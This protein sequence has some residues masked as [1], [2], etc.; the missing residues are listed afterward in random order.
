MATYQDCLTEKL[1]EDAHIANQNIVS[2]YG[3][4]LRCKYGSELTDHEV[5]ILFKVLKEMARCKN[6]KGNCHHNPSAKYFEQ[7]PDI[8]NG[9][10]YFLHRPCRYFGQQIEETATQRVL[11]SN[12][13]DIY[14]AKLWV[15]YIMDETNETAIKS[16]RI[17]L[18]K[19]AEGVGL[20]IYG[21]VGTGK[22]FLASLIA[23]EL[24]RSGRKIKWTTFDDL[25]RQLKETFKSDTSSEKS[26]LE[27]ISRC[28]VLFIDDLRLD[29][30]TNYQAEILFR[31][32]DSRYTARKPIYFT[33]TG[34]PE[35]L[36]TALNNPIDLKN[37]TVDGTA[38]VTRF[39]NWIYP[40]EI[41]GSSKR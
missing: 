3:D 4:K 24:L 8:I 21:E 35:Q 28:E 16:A 36:A 41:T 33:S 31:I 9:L 5:I 23:K 38:I 20:W 40:A 11:K 26:I 15:D 18:E 37:S 22:T 7:Y 2:K 10:L 14:K 1:L 25:I 19:F 29:R 6:C 13:P 39:K 32:V 27:T 30:I 17:A 12:I 34:D